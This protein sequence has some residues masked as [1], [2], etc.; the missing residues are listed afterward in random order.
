MKHVILAGTDPNPGKIEIDNRKL[1][2]KAAAEGFVLLKND[3]TLPLKDKKIPLYGSGARM[4]VKGG[5]GSGAV[6]ER[7]SVSIEEGLTNAGFEVTTGSWLDRFDR[8]Y[9]DTYEEYRQGVEEEVKGITDFYKILHL[10]GHFEYPTGIPITDDD[11]ADDKKR[12]VNTAIYV[13]SRQAGEGADRED[14]KGDYRLDDVE[15]ENLK[16]ASKGY[17]NFIVIINAGGVI[18]RRNSTSFKEE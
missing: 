14:K 13:L 18:D 3:G 9:A 1:A 5:T 8:Y 6:R 17:E 11:I 10:A 15:M 16:S 2:R 4:T 12:G 7:Y